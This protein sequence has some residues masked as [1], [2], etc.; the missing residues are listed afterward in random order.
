MDKRD[1]PRSPLN[2]APRWLPTAR[3]VPDYYIAVQLIVFGFE[4]WF[5]ATATG[6]IPSGPLSLL[7]PLA[8]LLSVFAALAA[9]PLSVA[10]LPQDERHFGCFFS[11]IHGLFL[12]V[13]VCMVY[14]FAT[15]PPRSL[16]L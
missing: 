13:A 5:L 8:L 16:S 11:A 1:K 4:L 12:L 9:V 10:M 15:H 6:L 3:R 14:Y 7:A 2:Y